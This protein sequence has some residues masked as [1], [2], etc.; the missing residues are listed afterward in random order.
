M[1]QQNRANVRRWARDAA[2]LVV[3]TLF[4]SGC[5]TAPPVAPTESL[6]AARDAIASAEQNDARQYAGS[7]LDEAR[8]QLERAEAAVSDERMADAR[9]Y[10][11]RAK[12]AAELASAKAD[13]AKAA[14]I[15]RQIR[16]SAEALK[17]E[18]RRTGEQQ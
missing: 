14:E 18:M 10:A 8:Q 15:N 2:I 13:A 9:R 17:E 1:D 16:R 11:E 12:V 3:I 4:L 7:E 6:E 5:A